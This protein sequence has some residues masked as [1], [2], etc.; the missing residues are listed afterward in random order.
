MTI[1]K[2]ALR[3]AA[4]KA[5]ALNL[6]TALEVRNH[7][8]QY[9]ECPTCCGDGHIEVDTDYCGIDGVA[10]QVLFYGIGE[11]HGL[12]EAYFRAANPATVL[13]LLDDLDGK[14]DRIKELDSQRSLAFMAC[15]RWRD[16]CAEAESKLEAAEQRNAE[17]EVSANASLKYASELENEIEN[18][19]RKEHH[20]DN[21]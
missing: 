7:D 2:Q 18:M 1:D 20:R 4:E 9:I 17:L 21:P 14:D 19:Q 16:K 15:N 12:A 11:H 5:T 8:D 6:D 10:L 13:A 3:E